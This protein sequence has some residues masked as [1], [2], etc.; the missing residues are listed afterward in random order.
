MNRWGKPYQE[1]PASQNSLPG[2]CGCLEANY[3]QQQQR[4]NGFLRV[5]GSAELFMTCP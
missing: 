5:R 4:D 3:C 1:H 2:S